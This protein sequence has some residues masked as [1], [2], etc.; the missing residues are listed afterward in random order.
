MTVPSHFQ[1]L[2]AA[3]RAQA[4][5]HQLLFVFATAELPDDPKPEQRERFLAGLGGA[6][7]PLMCVDK[8]PA[9]LADFE[10]LAAESKGAGPPWQLVFAA[11]LSGMGGRPPPA[12][13]IEGALQ[14]M[15][16]SVRAGAFSRFAAYGRDGEPVIFR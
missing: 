6:I 15:V 7:S 4:Q 9:E 11:A 10:T 8:S 5:P 1:Q 12:T 13:A 16:E 14:S 2:I 3:A